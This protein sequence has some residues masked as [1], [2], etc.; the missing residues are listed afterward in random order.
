MIQLHYIVEPHSAS[1]LPMLHFWK[2]IGK[3]GHA[4]VRTRLLP[5]RSVWAGNIANAWHNMEILQ[6][7]ITLILRCKLKFPAINFRILRA[8][9]KITSPCAP[10]SPRIT[11]FAFFYLVCKCIT[12]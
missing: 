10:S 4:S 6:S 9:V 2:K 5:S 11:S 3:G 1:R 8:R 12:I 7:A